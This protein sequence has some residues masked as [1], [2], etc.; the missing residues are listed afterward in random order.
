[1]GPYTKSTGYTLYSHFENIH[2]TG[3]NM[4]SRCM[5][6]D[7]TRKTRQQARTH[8]HTRTR[9]THTHTRSSRG[10]CA[11]ACHAI[12]YPI[13]GE[14]D[15]TQE[16]GRDQANETE[17]DK[18]KRERE[19]EKER[20]RRKERRNERRLPGSGVLLLLL[21]QPFCLYLARLDAFF[22]LFFFLPSPAHA[23][24]LPV[25]TCMYM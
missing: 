9:L 21:F 22:L 14:R 8:A 2:H 16:T 5:F 23:P 11:R 3:V 1:M 25:Q 4:S 7:L 24:P 18:I 15:K 12:G 13:Y 20:E 19:R 6:D 10:V 17:R